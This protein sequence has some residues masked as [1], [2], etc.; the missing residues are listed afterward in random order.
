MHNIYTSQEL[1]AL[2]ED[3]VV[4]TNMSEKKTILPPSSW[5]E[6]NFNELIEQKNLLYDQWIWLLDSGNLMHKEFEVFV[7]NI[8]NYINTR[9]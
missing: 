4:L 9:L 1:S 3:G 5:P 6:L 8:D 2:I 7:S